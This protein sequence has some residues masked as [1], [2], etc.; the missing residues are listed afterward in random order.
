[1]QRRWFDRSFPLGF[2]IEAFPEILERVRGTPARLEARVAGV[3]NGLRTQR[4][5]GNNLYCVATNVAVGRFCRL[6]RRP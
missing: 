6:R 4:V 1:M 3:A 2:P 5:D